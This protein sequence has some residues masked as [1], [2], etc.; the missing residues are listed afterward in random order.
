MWGLGL[1]LWGV[2]NRRDFAEECCL[3]LFLV[4]EHAP[5]VIYPSL[6][7]EFIPKV[8]PRKSTPFYA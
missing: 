6:G 4:Q 3:V 1:R 7:V 8:V 5:D 2:D